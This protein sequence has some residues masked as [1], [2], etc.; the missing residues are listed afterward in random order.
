VNAW[1]SWLDLVLDYDPSQGTP[2]VGLGDSPEHQFLVRS[3][4]D[5][6][7]RVTLDGRIKWV[8]PLQSVPAYTRL[9]LVTTWN[10]RPKLQ[11]MLGV[12]NLL[13]EHHPE[14]S[15]NLVWS[16]TEVERSILAKVSWQF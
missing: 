10:A 8:G 16:A 13:D 1:Y 4:L 15:N 14:F 6:P 3:Q 12:F 5:L 2:T 7:H 9:D 11:L